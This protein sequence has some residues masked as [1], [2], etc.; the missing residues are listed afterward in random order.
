MDLAGRDEI[1]FTGGLEV[2]DDRFSG[3]IAVPNAVL[4]NPQQGVRRKTVE[5]SNVHQG[6]RTLF[7]V[8]TRHSR[9]SGAE[10]DYLKLA[11]AR[12]DVHAVQTLPFVQLEYK[13]CLLC[14]M[15]GMGL[16]AQNRAAC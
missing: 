3:I 10:V 12:R 6:R 4:L 15:N 11:T 8:R 14:I 13:Y 16:L 2:V 1:Y 7:F 5:K 9:C